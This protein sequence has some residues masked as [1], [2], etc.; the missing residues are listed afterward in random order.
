MLGEP[1]L[2]SMLALVLLSE[3]PPWT[4]IMAAPLVLIGIVLTALDRRPGLEG[5][6]V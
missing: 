5:Q 1:I 3:V 6:E 2:A 4:V